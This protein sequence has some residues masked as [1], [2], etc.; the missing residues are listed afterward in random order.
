MSSYAV[1]SSRIGPTPSTSR[2]LGTQSTFPMEIGTVHAWILWSDETAKFMAWNWTASVGSVDRGCVC[3]R[4]D[5]WDLGSC[6]AVKRLIPTAYDDTTW[7]PNL[8]AHDREGRSNS[9]ARRRRAHTFCVFTIFSAYLPG[10]IV[11]HILNPGSKSPFQFAWDLVASSAPRIWSDSFLDHGGA[12]LIISVSRGTRPQPE[13]NRGRNDQVSDE[14]SEYVGWA[15]MPRAPNFAMQM[16]ENWNSGT[17]TV[18]FDTMW[19]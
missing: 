6:R 3:A 5:K 12:L 4:L 1:R 17:K 9:P 8:A 2:R 11:I 19:L 16:F 18:L 14:K 7:T 10:S 15:S 13:L